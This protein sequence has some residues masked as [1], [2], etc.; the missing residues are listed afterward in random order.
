[1]HQSGFQLQLLADTT[2]TALPKCQLSVMFV[3]II[4][5]LFCVPTVQ[6]LVV[7]FYLRSNHLVFR[8]F[9][10]FCLL[11]CCLQVQM[12]ANKM[13]IFAA[14]TMD[15]NEAQDEYEEVQTELR[16]KE[17]EVCYFTNC[18]MYVTTC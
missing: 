5:G 10:L 3:P 4:E 16:K 13:G 2:V 14:Y 1:M 11:I 9:F 8:L 12:V 17:E 18:H 7:A 6:C 15:A